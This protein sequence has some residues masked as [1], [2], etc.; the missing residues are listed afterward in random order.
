MG[1][2]DSIQGGAGT[3]SNMNAN[4]VV[5]NIAIEKLGGMKGDYSIVHPNDHVNL[6]LIHIFLL[7]GESAAQMAQPVEKPWIF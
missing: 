6:S 3:S 5:A 4:E 7:C 2:R 1:I